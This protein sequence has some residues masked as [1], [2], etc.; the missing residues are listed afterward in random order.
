[1]RDYYKFL[2]TALMIADILVNIQTD[3]ERRSLNS[4]D[5]QLGWR[6]SIAMQC[7]PTQAADRFEV[8]N[9]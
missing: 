5:N 6:K 1:V 4:L 3:T 8:L 2:R 9:N 7:S